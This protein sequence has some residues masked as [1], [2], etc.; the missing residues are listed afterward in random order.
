MNREASGSVPAPNGRLGNTA[1][2]RAKAHRDRVVIVNLILILINSP[3]VAWASLA[4]APLIERV[5]HKRLVFCCAAA[6]DEAL[7]KYPHLDAVRD[8]R[9]AAFD[10][11]GRTDMVN[12]RLVLT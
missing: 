8:G 5:G 10:S 7:R 12:E 11:H 4:F 3:V 9:E 6:S 2:D 1:A